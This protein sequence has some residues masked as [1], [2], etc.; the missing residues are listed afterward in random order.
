MTMITLIMTN[1][2]INM[3]SI[4]IIMTIIIDKITKEEYSSCIRKEN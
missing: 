1:K 3:T 4:I 2:I